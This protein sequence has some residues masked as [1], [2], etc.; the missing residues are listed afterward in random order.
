MDGLSYILAMFALCMSWVARMAVLGIKS[1]RFK[2]SFKTKKLVVTEMW[3]VFTSTEFQN[4]EKATGFTLPMADSTMQGRCSGKLQTISATSLIR[5]ALA[6][7]E[8][9]NFITTVT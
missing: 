4:G 2:T 7:D 3:A 9:P 5:C 8:P 6:T 1:S